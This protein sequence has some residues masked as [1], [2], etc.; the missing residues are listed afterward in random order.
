LNYL[1]FKEDKIQGRHAYTNFLAEVGSTE[2]TAPDPAQG[3][4]LSVDFS[5]APSLA[6]L[7]LPV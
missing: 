7:A 3:V 1:K 5:S 6:L 2:N 4:A